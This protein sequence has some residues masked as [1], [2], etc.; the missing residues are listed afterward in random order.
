MAMEIA[1]H[2]DIRLTQNVYTHVYD[3]AKQQAA[4][5]MD[6]LFPEFRAAGDSQVMLSRA[7]G[8]QRRPPAR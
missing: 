6:R 1:G 5:A 4:D 7:G 3:E 8:R 2:S